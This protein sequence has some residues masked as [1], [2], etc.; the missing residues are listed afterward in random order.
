LQKQQRS[1]LQISQSDFVDEIFYHE[2]EERA[3]KADQE[4][5]EAARRARDYYHR[6]SSQLNV[7]FD[8]D[9]QTTFMLQPM[10]LNA[11][12]RT[13]PVEKKV[14]IELDEKEIPAFPLFS[15]DNSKESDIHQESQLSH[16]NAGPQRS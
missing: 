16:V 8:T 3:K 9:N 5:R 1:S 13:T 10:I 12:H 15:S 7:C 4:R 2:I 6:Q 11:S 14:D